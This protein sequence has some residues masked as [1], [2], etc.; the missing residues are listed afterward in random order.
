M[1]GQMVLPVVEV[2]LHV[3]LAILF[4][5]REERFAPERK[6]G[7]LSMFRSLA[8]QDIDS[9]P[10]LQGSSPSMRSTA[11]H[12]SPILARMRRA[13]SATS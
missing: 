6:D 3:A 13:E 10:T 4:F 12:D 7:Q 5:R 2:R 8:S 9:F 11:P 1:R